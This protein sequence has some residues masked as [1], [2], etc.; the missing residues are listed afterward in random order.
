MFNLLIG[1]LVIATAVR[2]FAP[3]AVRLA[4]RGL[5]VVVKVGAA[6]LADHRRTEGPPRRLTE[7][8]LSLPV[9][10]GEEA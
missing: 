3:D 10:E 2:A 9:G 6:S 5:A 1:A 7:M 8:S 4:R